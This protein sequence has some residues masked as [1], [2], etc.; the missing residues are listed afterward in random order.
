MVMEKEFVS[1]MGSVV[2]F[3]IR[4]LKVKIFFKWEIPAASF[5]IPPPQ[6]AGNIFLSVLFKMRFTG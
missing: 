6:R 1:A 3:S 5:S 4:I 2:T